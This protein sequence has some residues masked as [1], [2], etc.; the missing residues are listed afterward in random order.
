MLGLKVIMSFSRSGLAEV[1]FEGDKMVG[2]MRPLAESPS[3]MVVIF[4]DT[5]RR[6]RLQREK[7]YKEVVKPLL[8]VLKGRWVEN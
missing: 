1:N 2:K 4:W 6:P 7:A 8:T 3:W 5:D